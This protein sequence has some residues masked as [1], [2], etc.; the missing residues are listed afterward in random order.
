MPGIPVMRGND[1]WH[2]RHA[3]HAWHAR[4]APHACHAWHAPGMLR[5]SDMPGVP[6]TSGMPGIPGGQNSVFSDWQDDGPC[7]YWPG[8]IIL[9]AWMIWVPARMNHPCLSTGMYN[10]MFS[11]IVS[12]IVPCLTHAL[13]HIVR[14]RVQTEAWRLLAC[15]LLTLLHKP[16]KSSR[17]DRPNQVLPQS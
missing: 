10:M 13:L 3:R 14:A 6:G 11:R 8:P 9:A 12:R 7:P 17:W 16:L 15:V 4:H 1:A 5:M 2:T